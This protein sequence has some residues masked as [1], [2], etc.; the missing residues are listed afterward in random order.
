[1]V[2]LA[3]ALH[4]VLIDCLG[5]N[6]TTF[7]VVLARLMIMIN[8]TTLVSK[9]HLVTISA[10]ESSL[11]AAELC[12]KF[13]VA[14]RTFETFLEDQFKLDSWVLSRYYDY[15]MIKFPIGISSSCYDWL[16]TSLASW[17]TNYQS[18]RGWDGLTFVSI[19]GRCCYGRRCLV[20]L[21]QN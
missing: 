6:W 9:C 18:S 2:K 3:I 13:L 5:A 14:V 7:L 21:G 1:M 12:I 11:G 15:L 20:R 19:S 4:T 8:W 10:Q 17:N 16:L